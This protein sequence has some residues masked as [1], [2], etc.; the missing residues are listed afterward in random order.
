MARTDL[1]A[2][3]AH[4]RLDAAPLQGRRTLLEVFDANVCGREAGPGKPH[5]G[6]FLLAAEA[7]GIAPARC[8]VVEDAPVGIAAA[9]AGGMLALGVARLHEEG[10]LV[11]EGA[12]V[13]VSR[14]DAGA[15]APLLAAAADAGRGGAAEGGES[16]LLAT[17]DARWVL[18]ETR[19]HRSLE[20]SIEARFAV[21]NGFIGVRASRAVS[22][23]P[24][25]V[26]W[27]HTQ[28]WA[29]WPRTYV[30]GLFDTPNAEPPVPALVPAPDWMR[31]RLLVDGA[32]LQLRLG[33]LVRHWRTL[34]MRRG[35]LVTDWHQR[36]ADG[37]LV[38]V[39]TLRLVSLA[40]RALALQLVEVEVDG[41]PARVELETLFEVGSTGLELMAIEPEVSLWRTGST[42]KTLA[43]AQQATLALSDAATVTHER[44]QCA[45]SW[46][47]TSRPGQR[48]TLARS[49]AFARGEQLDEEVSARARAACAR[50]AHQG[51]R[52]VLERHADAWAHRWSASDV[53][54]DGD[55]EAQRALRFAVYHLVSAAN[56]DDDAVS[57]GA[58]ALTGDAYLGHVFW[59]TEVYLLP[60]Y[61]LTWPEAARALLMY[62]YRT[63]GGARDKARRMGWRGA[64]YAWESGSTSA[65]TSRMRSGSTGSPRKT[66]PSCSKRARRSSLKR[67][68]SGQAAPRPKPTALTTSATSSA[69]TST[70]SISTTTRSPT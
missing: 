54:I 12:D 6:L 46:R 28:G 26:S 20:S 51:W 37:R 56:P 42:R 60:F 25:W 68:A 1:A 43:I 67:R 47:W 64:L 14:L 40:E 17:A 58:R 39:R 31:L 18:R 66:R 7:L 33:E 15:L 55:D 5:P 10:L 34:D 52:T 19:Y 16:A 65:P 2:F 13:V 49:L 45:S 11:A 62:R 44:G 9:K 27:Q 61:T 29:S 4:V 69:R 8:V 32:P 30:A 70:T 22:R 41:P 35:A 38:R 50:A 24:A 36:L 59:D 63:I 21:S 48:A 57:V 53:E 3:A 23:G